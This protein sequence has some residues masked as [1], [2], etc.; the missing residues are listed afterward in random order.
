MARA[1]IKPIDPFLEVEGTAL[2][3]KAGPKVPLVRAR[4]RARR[5]FIAASYISATW[6]QLTK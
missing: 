3:A 1:A 4:R 6:S 2:S 5:Y